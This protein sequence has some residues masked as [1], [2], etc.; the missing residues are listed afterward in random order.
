MDEIGYVSLPREICTGSSIMPHKHNPDVLEIMRA[1]Y[2]E[3]VAAE[4]AIRGM[5][6]NLISGYSRDLQLT[7]RPLM[8]S[9]ETTGASLRIM[10]LVMERITVDAARCESACTPELFATEE[11]YKLVKE[12][13]PFREAYRRVAERM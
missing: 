6:A 5:V 1:R 12:G 4:F 2:H 7:K 11:V 10:T 9:F 8:E 3:V 13:V